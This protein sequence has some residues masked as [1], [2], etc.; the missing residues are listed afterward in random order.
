[1]EV[2]FAHQHNAGRE[3]CH[4]GAD[5]L[6]P[7]FLQRFGQEADAEMQRSGAFNRHLEPVVG[8]VDL[9]G[10]VALPDRQDHVDRIGEDFVAVDVEQAE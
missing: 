9:V 5:D 6:W 1:M 4:Y 10:R 7:R 3:R 2:S 8:E